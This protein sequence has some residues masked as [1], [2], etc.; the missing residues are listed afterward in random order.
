M[1]FSS[2][3]IPPRIRLLLLPTLVLVIL[4]GVMRLIFL[5]WFNNPVDPIT[6]ANLL[7]A[8]YIGTKF[9]LRVALLLLL[10]M[11]ILGW[12]NFISPLTVQGRW[13]WSIYGSVAVTLLLLFYMVDF[14][15][16]AYLGKRLDQTALR[17][18]ADPLISAQMVWESYPVIPLMIL[19][20][21]SAVVTFWGGYR[22]LRRYAGATYQ[23]LAIKWRAWLIIGAV[24][25]YFFAIFAKISWY[26]LRWSDAY[27]STHPFTSALA[28]NPAVYFV[29]T[30][31]N[32]GAPY[33]EAAARSAYPAMAAYL[34][35]ENPDANSEVLQ[36][37]RQVTATPLFQ[38]SP[39]VVIVVL[40]SFATFKTGL[41]GN[42][43]SATPHF[44]QM[45]QQSIY[46]PN[47][48]TPHTGTARSLFALLTG[49]PDVQ[50]GETASRNPMIASQQ[51]IVNAFSSYK[52]FY[53]LGGSAS[54]GNIRALFANN[55]EGITLFEEGSYEAAAVD[56]WGISDL[57]LFRAANAQF[58]QQQQPF[59]AVVQTS[60]NHRPYT[61]PKDNAGFTFVEPDVDL[62]QHGFDSAG[63]YN[64]YRFMDHAI[65]EWMTMAKKEAYFANTLFVFFGD[66]G[67]ADAPGN[68]TLKQE[69]QLKMGSYRVPLIF[70]APNHLPAERRETVASEVD[71]LTTVAA[72]TGHSHLNTTFGR[73]LFDPTYDQARYAFTIDHATPVEIGLIGKDSYFKMIADG[74]QPLLHPL[75]DSEPRRDIT[76]EQ[77]EVAA[78]MQQLTLDYY[79]T[80]R[81]LLNHNQPVKR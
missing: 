52:K 72:I 5:F 47:F 13:L 12:I 29:Y 76:A 68:H 7:H 58:R 30:V 42:P 49:I 75:G 22:H 44:D 73:N 41:S 6:Y 9:D 16:Y 57:D 20:I 80:I 1:F 36:Y 33:D 8:L 65:G 46:F 59:F 77:P 48:F 27:F 14:G 78:R 25:L 2:S 61:I 56:V 81:Y 50:P 74:S 23:P 71:L 64:A 51:T 39:N 60:G 45:A 70:Y 15:H 37:Q 24:L 69:F 54:W 32:G 35:V 43:L 53:F 62:T 31:N 28:S 3:C 79:Q 10:P 67:L 19:L 55:I 21:V 18:A 40:E 34:G 66:H 38:Q 17:F 26:P 11:A 4:M 63:E